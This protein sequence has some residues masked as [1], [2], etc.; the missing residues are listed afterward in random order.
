MIAG[1]SE[2]RD[3]RR[4][5]SSGKGRSPAGQVLRWVGFSH[6]VLPDGCFVEEFELLGFLDVAWDFVLHG[7][8]GCGNTYLMTVIGAACARRREKARFFI[9]AE[10]VFASTGTNCGSCLEAPL[11]GAAKAGSLL[12]T[13]SGACHSTGA[14]PPFRVMSDPY[15]KRSLVVVANIDFS[16]WV[17]A[18]GGEKMA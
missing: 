17:A 2:L 16:K 5:V 6:V 9:A 4:R 15:E 7:Q 12:S 14:R 11:E 10:F 3:R 18:F 13:K 8:A 1:K